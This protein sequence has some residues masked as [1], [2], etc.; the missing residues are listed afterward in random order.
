MARVGFIHYLILFINGTADTVS[1]GIQKIYEKQA[2]RQ[3][4]SI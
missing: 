3:R 4:T 1:A 2:I